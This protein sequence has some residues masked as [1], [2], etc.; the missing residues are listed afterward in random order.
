MTQW[1]NAERLAWLKRGFLLFIITTLTLVFQFFMY[2]IEDQT[3]GNTDVIGYLYF[4]ISSFGHATLFALM[5]FLAIF[6]PLTLFTKWYKT[7]WGLLAF[8]GFLLNILAYVNG[9]VFQ[10]YKFHINGFV[11][12]LVLGEDAG[13]IFVFNAALIWRITGQILIIFTLFGTL[14]YCGY[15][16][17]RLV[18]TRRVKLYVS[19][20]ALCL[21]LSHISHAYAAAANQ[22]SIQ[23]VAMCLPQFYPLTANK[24]MM[25]LG[26]LGKDN[27]YV[28]KSNTNSPFFYPKH[29]LVVSDTVPP[30]NIVFL[31]LD[32]W[33]ARTFTRENCPNITAFGD[34]AQVFPHH[35]STGCQTK[36]GMFGL[37]FGLAG[38]YWNEFEISGTQPL[39]IKTLLNKGY[40]VQ[41]Y[42]SAHLYKPPLYRV[43]FADVPNARTETPGNTSFERDD[44]IQAD[45]LEY[46]DKYKESGSSK[47]FFS[48]MFYDLLHSTEI[49]PDHCDKF[50][51]SWEYADYLKLNNDLDP[52]P[53]FN[54]YR[55]CVF[56]LDSLVGQVINKLKEND[57]L[58]NTIVIVTGDHGEE[59]NDNRKN[60]WGH[61]SNFSDAQIHIPM[62]YYNPD[63]SHYVWSH[64][65]THLDVVPTLMSTVLGVENPLED[66]SMG[67]LLQDTVRPPYHI[68]G[69]TESYAFLINN[70][71][72]EKKYAGRIVALD[73]ALNVIN[74]RKVNS[75]LLLEA[76]N[77]KNHFKRK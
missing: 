22:I 25:R 5:P 47:P 26:V 7:S 73:S 1:I 9:I 63:L 54:L 51:P 68:V 18:I 64:N 66:Y 34:E 58:K 15:K 52:T 71:I 69:E 74:D 28:D 45:F 29:E 65:T 19:V 72:Y 59:Y 76:I 43:I 10:L 20:V 35:R 16:Y 55:N 49:A 60:F 36:G 44:R 75:A 8:L 48:L 32:S 38:T 14:A 30:K 53:Y 57:M 61:G 41:L 46:L 2:L 24:L 31:I 70:T 62:V 40:D 6:L 39:F 4:S 12:D 13:Q 11:L 56:H 23:N 21:F 37:F 77:Y 17:H 42:P 67:R 3:S 50:Q 33:N 27:Q